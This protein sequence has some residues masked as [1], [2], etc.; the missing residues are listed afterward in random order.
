MVSMSSLLLRFLGLSGIQLRSGLRNSEDLHEPFVTSDFTIVPR[1]T[2]MDIASLAVAEQYRRQA[3]RKVG[4]NKSGLLRSAA[5]ILQK[6]VIS[7]PHLLS[8]RLRWVRVLLAILR[9]DIRMGMQ[10]GNAELEH[11]ISRIKVVLAECVPAGSDRP[12]PAE[13]QLLESSLYRQMYH[14][15]MNIDGADSLFTCLNYWAQSY[16]LLLQ[17]HSN[18]SLIHIGLNVRQ[19]FERRKGKR[20]TELLVGLENVVSLSKLESCAQV[21]GPIIAA[22]AEMAHFLLS[23][24][25][26]PPP[27]LRLFCVV[28]ELFRA[29]SNLND[30]L[31]M[32]INKRSRVSVNALTFEFLGDST[33]AKFLALCDHSVTVLD[34][35]NCFLTDDV[36]VLFGRLPNLVSLSL[37]NCPML[38]DDGLMQACGSL[39]RLVH[40]DI[41]QCVKIT[42][43]ALSRLR[44]PQLQR[45]NLNKCV[46]LNGEFLARKGFSRVQT[47]SLNECHRIGKSNLSRI[48]S[49]SFPA[50]TNLSLSHLH[51]ANSQVCALLFVFN[52]CVSCLNKLL[53]F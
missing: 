10:F 36:V 13:A 35:S 40:L 11:E 46:S 6:A 32:W 41:S 51:C 3:K 29:Q 37:S 2:E 18:P 49:E 17:S 28:I 23:S 38:S 30:L 1:I 16:Q 48:S 14:Q 9:F 27:R 20:W 53:F 52:K 15:H 24:L 19:R 7:N 4:S 43:H 12:V 50:L 42:D 44:L 31:R 39:Q 8:N 26:G 22:D 47:L 21:L 5:E 34:L 33:V 45:L 25:D